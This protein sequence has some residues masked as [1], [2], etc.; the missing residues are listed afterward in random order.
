MLPTTLGKQMPGQIIWMETLHHQN[1]DSTLLI[2]QAAGKSMIEPAVDLRT[3]M[4]IHGLSWINR[5]IHDEE[6]AAFPCHTTTNRSRHA[7]STL[8]GHELRFLILVLRQQHIWE[9]ALV[10]RRSHHRPAIDGMF[11]C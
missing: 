8:H 3:P 5:I 7:E 9:K 1:N 4:H 6:I 2:I 11:Q 10:P